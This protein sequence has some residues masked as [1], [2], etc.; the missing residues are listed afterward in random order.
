MEKQFEPFLNASSKGD[1]AG[2]DRAFV[3]FRMPDDKAFFGEYFRAEDVEQL[4]WD[5]DAEVDG[6]ETTLK[7]MMRVIARGARFHARCKPPKEDPRTVV[8]ER[9]SKVQPV[10]PVPVEQFAIEFVADN[11]KRF[12]F[13]GNFV[14]VGGAYRYVGKGAFPF[15]S[16]PDANDPSKH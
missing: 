11:G 9:E 15:W 2:Q 13:L 4:G 14:Y 3:I 7:T 10:K 1:T 16:M 8:K 5:S 12:S 6:E